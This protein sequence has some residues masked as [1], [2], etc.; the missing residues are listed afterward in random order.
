ME[1]QQWRTRPFH[2]KRDNAPKY[3]EVIARFVHYVE[4]TVDP[5]H[6]PVE[7]GRAVCRGAVRY[8]GELVDA[9]RGETAAK[10]LLIGG[11]H[12]DAELADFLDARPA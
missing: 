3:D 5:R 4:V 8:A 11:K 7:D 9:G 1:K 2:L 12:V 6:H 10:I